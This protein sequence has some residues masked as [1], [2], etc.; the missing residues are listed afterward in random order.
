M[1][2]LMKEVVW[3]FGTSATGKETFIKKVIK[4]KELQERMG[5]KN[6]S[7]SFCSESIDHIGQFDG[8]PAIERRKMILH[9][10]PQL[11]E[12]NDIV[13]IKWQ[14]VDSKAQL[15]QKLKKVTI[16]A[17]HVIIRLEAPEQELVKRLRN[18]SWWH[19]YGKELEFIHL[20]RD[21]V[22]KSISQLQ[23]EFE[24]KTINSSNSSE[25][26]LS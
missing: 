7:I 4:D 1:I 16:K 12:N 26:N 22:R 8:D 14:I 2:S 20:E 11:L 6:K 13:L 23:N 19:D 21:L 24:V 18:K 3:I 15:P 25:Y 17:K 5:W 10:V 9:K